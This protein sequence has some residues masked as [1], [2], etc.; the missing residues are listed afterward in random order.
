MPNPTTPTP[1]PP[2]QIHLSRLVSL[3]IDAKGP[4]GKNAEIVVVGNSGTEYRITV[5]N[6]LLLPSLTAVD[7][8]TLRGCFTE[9]CTMLSVFQDRS[10]LEFWGHDGFL[11]AIKGSTL[12][13]SPK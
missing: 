8:P 9:A 10:A 2:T 4:V 7:E 5:E 6:P 3:K 12:T 11:G 13:I 1:Q